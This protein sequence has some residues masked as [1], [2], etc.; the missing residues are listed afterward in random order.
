MSCS[1]HTSRA[2]SST[3]RVVSAADHAGELAAGPSGGAQRQQKR[4]DQPC[5]GPETYKSRIEQLD[6][7]AEIG[8]QRRGKTSPGHIRS[9]SSR[10]PKIPHGRIHSATSSTR[11]GAAS[12]TWG[13]M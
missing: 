3:Q 6:V 8:P 10:E 1:I 13:A 12:A 11:N 9:S 2:R 4:R 7:I 5:G